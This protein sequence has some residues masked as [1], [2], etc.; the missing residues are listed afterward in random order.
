[1]GLASPCALNETFFEA[2][3]AT[4]SD[5]DSECEMGR[6]PSPPLCPGLLEL[7]VNYKRWL[8]RTERTELLLV[9]ADIVSSRASMGG[10]QLR[11]RIEGL[12]P[13]W[14]VSR[15]IHSI[16]D[17]TDCESY[18]IGISS[19]Y[20][21]ISLGL[22]KYDVLNEVPFKEAEYLLARHGLS[23]DCL[24]TLHHLV[25]LRVEGE[26]CILPF[27][28]PPTLPL[29]RTLRVLEAG[30]I[31]PSF[32]AGQTFHK[33]E[34]C[35]MSLSGKGRKL[36][37]DPVT[38]MPVCTRLD[39]GD[40][41]LLATLK[42]PQL[43][44]L[45]VSF[46]HPKFIII[47]E[48]HVAVNA[49]LSGLELLHVYG[50]YQR[51]DLIQV[52][53]CLPVLKSLIL[54]NGSGLDADFFE[55]FLLMRPNETSVSM[56]SHDEGRISATLCPLLSS[57]L[58]EGYDPIEQLELMPLFKEIVALRAVTGSPLKTFTLSNSEL[59]KQFELIGSYGTFVVKEVSF[60]DGPEPF[61][62][63]I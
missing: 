18:V 13:D 41:T 39:V 61:R 22:S 58:I 24:L 52:L 15:R 7:N 42:L 17:V 14:F 59:K 48:R 56:Q 62:L 1:M 43:C 27:K 3:V 29:F 49:N 16:R 38:Q 11:L 28:P 5:A 4:D 30:N 21:I 50:K 31:Y 40:I 36:S 12:P 57:L 37:N 19:P 44:E 23:I 9:F 20:G 2:F 45:G 6:L 26:E 10:F 33:L 51:A 47:W 54:A 34:K 8:R 63:D 32:L 46:D 60:Y 35:R 53:R 25:E 55:K